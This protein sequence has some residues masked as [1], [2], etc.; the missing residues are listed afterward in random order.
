MHS[1]DELKQEIREQ[2]ENIVQLEACKAALILERDETMAGE[3][4]DLRIQVEDA[5]SLLMEFE[6]EKDR[7]TKV[8]KEKNELLEECEVNIELL[9]ENIKNKD[10][11]SV[12]DI[13]SSNMTS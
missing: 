7:E 3:M 9:E 2:E 13:Y 10:Q 1:I 4:R 12:S 11:V 6:E 8:M 5:R